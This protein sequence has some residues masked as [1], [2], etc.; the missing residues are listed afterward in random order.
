MEE[1]TKDA[2]KKGRTEEDRDLIRDEVRYTVACFADEAG[3]ANSLC[4]MSVWVFSVSL[5]LPAACLLYL[6]VAVCPSVYFL[7][8]ACLF[9]LH[10]PAP[11][12]NVRPSHARLAGKKERVKVPAEVVDIVTELAHHYAGTFH[13]FLVYLALF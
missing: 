11:P 13:Y 1:R 12:F 8:A 9:L 10:A 5:C 6:F 3:A 7:P 4:A 2:F